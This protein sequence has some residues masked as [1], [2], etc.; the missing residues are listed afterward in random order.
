MSKRVEQLK[1]QINTASIELI[2]H[3]EPDERFYQNPINE[4]WYPS[5]TTKLDVLPKD[6]FLDMWKEKNGV[7]AVNQVM[8]RQAEKGTRI[9]NFIDDLC[10]QY[11][12]HGSVEVSW[13]NEEGYKIMTSEEWLAVCKFVDFFNTYVKSIILSEQKMFS[14]ELDVSGTVDAVFELVDE[15]IALVDYKY[16]AVITDKFSVQTWCYAKMVEEMFGVKVDVRGNLWL[17][18]Q[19]RGRDKKNLVMQ[20]KGWEFVEHNEDERD[21][22]IYNCAHTIFMD[23]YRKKEI[24][25]EHRTYPAKLIL[26]KK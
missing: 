5:V 21:E 20:G 2:Q 14:D 7:E 19:K 8:V 3:T 23:K 10:K 1:D 13:F 22:M 26:E 17:R 24:I 18:S 9:H 6:A 12:L 11:Q 16:T 25:P 4:R 15:R